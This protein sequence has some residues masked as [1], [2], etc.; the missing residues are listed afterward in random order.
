MKTGF[1]ESYIFYL[2]TVMQ[3]LKFTFSTRVL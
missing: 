1:M 3:L 2:Q